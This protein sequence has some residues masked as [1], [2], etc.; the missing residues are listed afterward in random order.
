MN[1]GF[2]SV[3]ALLGLLAIAGTMNANVQQL[4]IVPIPMC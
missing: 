4:P 3:V 1:R 2:P